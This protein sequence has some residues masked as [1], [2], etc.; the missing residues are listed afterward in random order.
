M[1]DEMTGQ[2]TGT[3]E[4][5][6]SVRNLKSGNKTP[7]RE[8][9]GILDGITPGE[10]GKKDLNFKE[11]EVVESIEPYNFPTAT[12]SIKYS[13]RLDSG[14]GIFGESLVKFLGEDED[15]KDTYGLRFHMKMEEGHEYSGKDKETGKPFVGDVWRV[16]ELEGHETSEAPANE[17]AAPGK[18]AVKANAAMAR[19]IELL[20]GKTLAEFNKAA[21]ADPIIRK[22]VAFQKTIS[23][24]S[25]VKQV[26]ADGLFT[27]DKTDTYHLTASE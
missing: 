2:D 22:D 7:L 14:W 11:V 13:N 12:L 23:D 4:E 10:F 19:A 27:K 20:D 17:K 24:K 5:I 3:G 1:V 25:F 9:T 18:P 16:V 6:L 21:Y 15:V 26:M 8:F